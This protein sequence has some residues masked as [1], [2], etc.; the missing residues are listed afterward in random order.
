MKYTFVF[1]T[2]QKTKFCI[3]SVTLGDFKRVGNVFWKGETHM[4]QISEKELA[5]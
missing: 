1:L 5:L 2:K 4:D 3:K